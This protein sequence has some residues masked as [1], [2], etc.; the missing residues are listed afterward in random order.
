MNVE[1]NLLPKK[2]RKN[3]FHI[4]LLFLVLLIVVLMFIFTYFYQQN[5]EQTKRHLDIEIQQT[6]A[7]QVSLEQQATGAD[8]EF[9]E[10]ATIVERLE[11]DQKPISR[12]LEV[13]VSQLPDRGF[14]LEF[15]YGNEGI[16]TTDVQF[17]SQREAASYLHALDGLTVVQ[18]AM[19]DEIQTEDLSENEVQGS[20]EMLPR[21][22]ATYTINLNTDV[23]SN[24]EFWE[25]LDDDEQEEDVNE[26]TDENEPIEDLE[27]EDE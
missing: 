17:D 23:L 16:I 10:F 13:L 14:M 2:A 15:E 22:I 6:I 1:I 7:L 21:Y 12:L 20:G 11:S 5:L 26:E 25:E 8:S 9:N 24:V 19:V 3:R 18:E 27:G 4:I